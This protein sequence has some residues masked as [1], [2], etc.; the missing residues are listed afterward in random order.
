MVTLTMESGSQILY[1]DSVSEDTEAGTFTDWT[2]INLA[3]FGYKVGGGTITNAIV[4]EIGIWNRT[5]TPTEVTQLYNDGLGVQYTNSFNSISATLVSPEDNYNSSS[6][7]VT[8]NWTGETTETTM[9]NSTLYINNLINQT[10]IDGTSNYTYQEL[11]LGFPDG[12]YNWSVTVYD[13]SGYSATTTE[14]FFGIDTTTPAVNILYPTGNIA[15]DVVTSPDVTVYLNWSASDT[16][17]ETCWYYNNT[18]NVTVACGVNASFTL[19]YGTYTH[20]V[21]A[22]DTYGTIGSDSQTTTYSYG[23][24]QNSL[25]HNFTSYETSQESFRINVTKGSSYTDITSG[26]LLYNG[27]SY[28]GT[29]VDD[30]ANSIFSY[31]F[32][33]PLLTTENTP[34]N[35]SVVWEIGLDST[36]YFNSSSSSQNVLPINITTCH[37]GGIMN[38]TFADEKT[39]AKINATTVNDWDYY[40]G[41]GSIYRSNS[42]INT[43]AQWEYYYCFEPDTRNVTL[44]GTS[45]HDNPTYP[46]REYNYAYSYNNDSIRDIVVYLLGTSDGIYTTFQVLSPS[47]DSISGVSATVSTIVGGS[48]LQID[49]G[50]TGDDGEVTFWV[51]P[52]N[53]HTFLFSKTGYD[54]LSVSLTPTQSQYTVYMGDTA[55][56]TTLTNF[57]RGIGYNIFPL[58]NELTN[59]TVYSFNFSLTSSYHNVN[60]YGFWLSNSSTVLK[61]ISGLTN[62]GTL[63]TSVSTGTSDYL[64]MDY[65]WNVDGNYTNFTRTWIIVSENKGYGVLTFFE[66]LKTYT[67][68]EIFGLNAWSRTLIIFLIIFSI[69]GV[70]SYYTGTYNPFAI[71]VLLFG[72]VVIFDAVLGMIPSPIGAVDNFAT[73]ISFFMMVIAGIWEVM[74]R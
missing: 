37:D 6:K 38:V 19:P 66:H 35:N 55:S 70:S 17:L 8:F 69:V 30:G 73:I 12:D 4:D 24:L 20:I 21:Y 46:Q 15:Y 16:N 7:D 54:D 51:N 44:S 68:E 43:T 22:N 74:N 60:S 23:L 10:V 50:V 14:R 39:L 31:S 18:A 1:M 28:V 49:A 52:D 34:E 27:T 2:N 62:G 61:N 53:S 63:N 65:Y 42:Y 71:S 33:N 26:S 72:L 67:D 59:N 36:T 3:L 47:G 25:N 41:D 57:V 11:T 32:Y 5:L 9:D 56:N 45:T 40:M 64:V 58:E 29:E 13:S 48:L